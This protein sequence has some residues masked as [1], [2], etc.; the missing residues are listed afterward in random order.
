[1]TTSDTGFDDRLA[2]RRAR[3]VLWAVAIPLLL[4]IVTFSGWLV[5]DGLQHERKLQALCISVLAVMA[6]LLWVRVVRARWLL[7]QVQ[8]FA[9][10]SASEETGVWGVGGPGMRTPGATGI[11]TVLPD[12]ARIDQPG[13]GPRPR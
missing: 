10:S 8:I 4:V 9:P 6:V 3:R 11:Y 7:L 5:L 13:N 1:M 12:N 2:P